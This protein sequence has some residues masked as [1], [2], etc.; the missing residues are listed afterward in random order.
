MELHSCAPLSSLHFFEVILEL[1]TNYS[2]L[3]I[4]MLIQ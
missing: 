2:G 3:M 4:N 1:I